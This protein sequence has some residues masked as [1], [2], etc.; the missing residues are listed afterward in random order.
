VSSGGRQ[1]AGLLELLVDLLAGRAHRAAGL[2]GLGHREHLAAQRLDHRAHDGTLGDLV[3]ADVVEDLVGA[4]GVGVLDVRPLED[5]G[6]AH[7]SLL[8]S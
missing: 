7:E 5:V 2:G 3:L 1:S 8:L 4:T 6:T